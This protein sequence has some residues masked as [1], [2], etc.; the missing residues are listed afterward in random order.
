M[1]KK[2]IFVKTTLLKIVLIGFISTTF[3]F[4]GVRD[5]RR[6]NLEVFETIGSA[7][8]GGLERLILWDDRVALDILI[9]REMK[10]HKLIDYIFITRNNTVIYSTIK[11]PISVQLIKAHSKHGKDS[12]FFK[13]RNSDNEIFYDLKMPIGHTGTV[14]RMGVSRYKIDKSLFP[15]LF[16][17]GLISMVAFFGCVV[18]SYRI[19]YNAT[20][21]IVLL[22]EALQFYND[23]EDE[24]KLTDLEKFRDTSGL[25]QAFRTL[26]SKR[27][28]NKKELLHSHDMMKYII[29][30]SRDAVAVLDN[31]LRYL[32]VSKRYLTDYKI[33]E[34]DIIGKS[35][36][37]ILPHFSK[38]WQDNHFQALSGKVVFSEETVY[39]HADG[40][41]DWIRWENRPWYK[42]DR[43][44]GGIVI[45][46]EIITD[47]KQTEFALME[48][49]QHYRQLFDKAHEGIFIM[50][51]EWKMVEVNQA[52]ADMHGYTPDELKQ[53]DIRILYVDEGQR[54][55][56]DDD[57]EKQIRAGKAGSL[58]VKHY[59]KDGHILSHNVTVSMITIGEKKYY[60]AFHQDV[61][62]QKKME[63][64]LQQAQKLESLGTLAGGIAHDFNN[65]L[66]PIIGFSE[67]IQEELPSDSLAYQG[68]DEIT[69]AARQA[70]FLVKQ[71]L[72]FSRKSPLRKA[73]LQLQY[74]LNDALKL[75]RA[76]IPANIEI[77]T[78]I[79]QNCGIVFADPVQ[80]HQI[81][82]NLVTNAYHA[83]EEHGG[84]ITVRLKNVDSH[85]YTS[86]ESS[87]K[88]YILLTVSDTGTGISPEI[89]EKIFEPYFTTKP[90]GKG[91]GLG[92]SMVYGIV[93]EHDGDIQIDSSPSQGTTISIYFPLVEDGQKIPLNDEVSNLETG[94]EK[95]LL[96]D[97]EKAIVLIEKRIL[98]QLGYHVTVSTSSTEALKIFRGVPHLFDLIITDASMPVMTGEQLIH[99]FLAIKPEIPVI[100]CTGFS[101]KLNEKTAFDLGFK[102]FLQ[103]PISR[104]QLA[105]MVRKVLD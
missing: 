63:A 62:E 10:A 14:L 50:D 19:A 15:T 3:F 1:L 36:Y 29:E 97:D 17:L 98:E 21:E 6:Y 73:S 38:N 60:L 91:T 39:L 53:M 52:F 84:S 92:L 86:S 58:E 105:G 95:I 69:K 51:E 59:H 96:I 83:V 37:E 80:I 61:T 103:K 65:L 76:T 93:K 82:M 24:T 64:R 30:Y 2:Q 43:S 70:A 49:E 12:S 31:E 81:V 20:K 9:K 89:K 27:Q 26:V 28:E 18:L 23:S 57:I 42:A 13:Y 104:S 85:A 68:A 25:T 35:L 4:F 99:E 67:V 7:M 77:L 41:E 87:F 75:A 8:V 32:F 5:H 94:C 11:G 48:R 44:I 16:T 66:T 54:K 72:F 46:S 74:V 40:S 88:K 79:D 101:E 78:E 90:L 47:R 45:Y 55:I 100:A 34:R 102:G 33:K 56:G 22:S 71:I